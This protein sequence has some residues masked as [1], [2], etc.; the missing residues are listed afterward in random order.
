MIVQDIR[1]AQALI[2]DVKRARAATGSAESRLT[3]PIFV[4]LIQ[5]KHDLVTV[6]NATKV[7]YIKDEVCRRTL[8]PP[9]RQILLPY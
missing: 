9:D 5:A 2:E 7:L 4:K 8:F 1:Q 3:F 6:S